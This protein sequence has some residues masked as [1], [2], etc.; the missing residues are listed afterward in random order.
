LSTV[1]LLTL[2]NGRKINPEL[3]GIESACGMMGQ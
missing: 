1:A 3:R 2:L